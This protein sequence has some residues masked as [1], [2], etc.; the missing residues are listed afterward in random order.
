M[1]KYLS[2]MKVSYRSETESFMEVGQ[3]SIGAVAPQGGGSYHLWA[4]NWQKTVY[5]SEE[6]NIYSET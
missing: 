5:I 3:G 2:K 1:N 6:Y 4:C